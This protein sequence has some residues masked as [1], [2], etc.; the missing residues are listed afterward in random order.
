MT[1]WE[2]P[3]GR[4]YF[5]EERA[6]LPVSAGAAGG[7]RT[8]H[9]AGPSAVTCVRGSDAG[10]GTRAWLCPLEADGV[11]T[12][13]PPKPATAAG[14]P[15]PGRR[16]APRGPAGTGEQ[17]PLPPTPPPVI[18]PPPLLGTQHRDTRPARRGTGTWRQGHARTR[19]PEDLA[20][21]PDSARPSSPRGPRRRRA[22]VFQEGRAE[23]V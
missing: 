12:T 20:A 17:R 16:R 10:R 21:T 19:T 6:A 14:R 22:S 15:L 8:V 18:V 23:L 1:D 11:R 4:F 2:W 3:T 9:T 5:G 7:R 13:V